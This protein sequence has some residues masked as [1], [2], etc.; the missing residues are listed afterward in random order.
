M[1]GPTTTEEVAE[2]HLSVLLQ[3]QRGGA[4]PVAYGARE[5]TPRAPCS[6]KK[7]GVNENAEF[8]TRSQSDT[9]T[10]TLSLWG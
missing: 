5:L 6:G 3:I 4:L 9:V 2:P 1:R 10:M 7:K 8:G